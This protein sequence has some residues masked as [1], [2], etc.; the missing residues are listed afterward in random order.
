MSEIRVKSTG[1]I[2]LFES[3]NTSSVTIASPASLSANRTITIPDADVTLGA[4]VSL[5]GSTNNQVTTVTGA[6]AITG[7]TNFIYNGTI[8]GAGADGANADLGTGVHIKSGD[9]GQGSVEAEANLLI[10]E[11]ASGG[12]LSIYTG[13]SHEAKINFGDSGNDN[14]GQIM[15]HHNGDSMRFNTN[16]DERMRIHSNGVIS[17]LNGIALGVGTA[18]TASNVLDDYEEG[19][20]TPSWSA[21]G[22]SLTGT[23]SNYGKYTKIGDMVSLWFGA[24]IDSG[25]ASGYYRITNAPFTSTTNGSG[26]YVNSQ[27]G[28]MGTVWW[29]SGG[30]TIN[31]S[32][33]DATLETDPNLKVNIIM[34]V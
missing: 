20:W 28:Y 14:Q 10:L 7:E 25:T 23:S 8:V 21:G 12:G 30:T 11:S 31:M 33:Y 3:D 16:N 15:Y 5:T 22:G 19:T 13:N 4:G 26:S 27:S 24:T 9:S 2:K 18:N 32:K 1:T 34:K 17:C 29:D 6:N